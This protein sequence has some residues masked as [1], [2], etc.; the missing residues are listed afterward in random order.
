MKNPALGK[1]RNRIGSTGLNAGKRRGRDW[2][3]F[4]GQN[5][6]EILAGRGL[7]LKIKYFR[8]YLNVYKCKYFGQIS[9]ML[10]TSL[11]G[12]TRKA[13]IAPAF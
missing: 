5:R 10:A 7:T 11:W 13:Y 2:M 6:L 4:S 8:Y 3:E 1:G 12:Y 9:R